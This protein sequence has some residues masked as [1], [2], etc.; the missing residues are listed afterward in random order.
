MTTRLPEA[1]TFPVR[2][3]NIRVPS[4]RGFQQQYEAAVP[5]APLDKIGELV[6]RQAPWSDMIALVQASAPHGF[7]VY[8][9]EDLHRLLSLAGNPGDSRDSV[10]YLMGN[11][12]TA[13]RMYRHDARTL[14]YAPLRTLIWEDSDGDA[15]FSLEQ[16]SLLF[17]SL[18]DRDVTEVGMELDREL[19]A[20]LRFL[21]LDV[22][23]PLQHDGVAAGTG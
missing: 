20:L 4:V 9:K 15:W 22:P 5:P 11:H 14:L 12:V 3:L 19:A 17:G 23:R 1:E 6:Q 2:R 8:F 13:E 10:M 18:G 21:G 16:P 7:L